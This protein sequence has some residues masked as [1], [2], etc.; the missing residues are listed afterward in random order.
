MSTIIET[1]EERRKAIKQAK[2]DHKDVIRLNPEGYQTERNK[3]QAYLIDTKIKTK[4][5]NNFEVISEDRHLEN[6]FEGRP[7]SIDVTTTQY[8]GQVRLGYSCVVKVA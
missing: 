1:K 7:Q 5:S 2:K 4:S 3:F 6:L 8:Q